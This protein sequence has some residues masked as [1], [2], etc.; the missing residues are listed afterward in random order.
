M[1]AVSGS[2]VPA[3]ASRN[4]CRQFSGL[5]RSGSVSPF[6]G[7]GRLARWIRRPPLEPPAS[8]SGPSVTS[9]EP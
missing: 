5:R 9:A 7:R 8:A 2:S 4:N 6:R 1:T 3:P